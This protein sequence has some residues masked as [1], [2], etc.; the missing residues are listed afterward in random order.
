MYVYRGFSSVGGLTNEGPCELKYKM[1]GHYFFIKDE[2][3]TRML[4]CSSNCSLITLDSKKYSSVLVNLSRLVSVMSG[5]YFLDPLLKNL[6][7]L[8]ISIKLFLYSKK[9]S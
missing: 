6:A 9:T 4:R 2:I 7:K 8:T 5:M 3:E 1:E